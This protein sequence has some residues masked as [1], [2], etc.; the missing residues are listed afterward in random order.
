MKQRKRL[1]RKLTHRDVEAAIRRFRARGGIIHRLPD[2]QDRRDKTVGQDKY[3]DYE[4]L[5][6]LLFG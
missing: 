1:S 4:P 6:K 2:Q 3:E 5:S